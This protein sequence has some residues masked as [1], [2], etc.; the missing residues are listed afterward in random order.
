MSRTTPPSTEYLLSEARDAR[1]RAKG[2][3]GPPSGPHRIDPYGDAQ[4]RY[5]LR[6]AAR[7]TGGGGGDADAPRAALL[8]VEA[9]RPAPNLQGSP[10]NAYLHAVESAAEIFRLALAADPARSDPLRA[11]AQNVSD[12]AQKD[13]NWDGEY[14]DFMVP[15]EYIEALRAALEGAK[16]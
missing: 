12:H 7:Q 1:E 5:W 9:L 2:P 6:E 4:R 11:A 15:A 10:V 14:V 16:P 3:P 8:A 13:D